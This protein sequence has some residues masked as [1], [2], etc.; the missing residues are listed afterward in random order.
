MIEMLRSTSSNGWAHLCNKM[1]DA[2]TNQHAAVWD[3]ALQSMDTLLHKK[4]NDVAARQHAIT[5]KNDL[6]RQI[7]DLETKLQAGH[8]RA[9]M[10]QKLLREVTVAIFEEIPGKPEEVVDVQDGTAAPP[11][12]RVIGVI[13]AA[14]PAKRTLKFAPAKPLP[15]ANVR[16]V[17]GEERNA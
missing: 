1:A 6:E 2:I 9:D 3:A 8:D 15:S 16:K 17:K 10:L 11:D 5:V 4:H 14:E 13:L 12:R 7:R